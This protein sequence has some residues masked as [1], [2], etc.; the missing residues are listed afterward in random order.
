MGW[1]ATAD[2]VNVTIPRDTPAGT[3]EIG[4]RGTNQG[5]TVE[6]TIPVTVTED[7][8]TANPPTTTSLAPGST[9]G[10]THGQDPRVVAGSDRP[11]IRDRRL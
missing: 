4:V 11:V 6:G 2:Q 10:R 3:Y 8:P 1:T 9:I 5:R 7:D